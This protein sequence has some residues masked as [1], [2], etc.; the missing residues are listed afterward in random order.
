MLHS[1]NRTCSAQRRGI[2]DHDDAEIHQNQKLS[3]FG[4]NANDEVD[5]EDFL[6]VERQRLMQEEND[7]YSFK[8]RMEAHDEEQ[9]GLKRFVE[10]ARQKLMLIET[11]E[12]NNKASMKNF[13]GDDDLIS[14]K[15]RTQVGKFHREE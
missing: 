12:E 5:D 11:S 4:C 9:E 6:Q 3:I 1:N 15:K 8:S 7:D 14:K 13:S 10:E 2:D